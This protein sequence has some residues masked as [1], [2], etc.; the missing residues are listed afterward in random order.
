LVT[1]ITELPH[2]RVAF[3]VTTARQATARRAAITR[4]RVTVITL[5]SDRALSDPIPTLRELTIIA[6]EVIVQ[7]VPII[8]GLIE[9]IDD[10]VTT[11]S[12]QA[13]VGTGVVV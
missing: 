8:A 12:W 11:A 2:G 7:A 13:A 4:R 3:S 10:P 9:F 1:V 5:L 6:A